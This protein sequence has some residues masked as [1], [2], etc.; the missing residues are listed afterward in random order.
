MKANLNTISKRAHKILDNPMHLNPGIESD[1]LVTLDSSDKILTVFHQGTS[2]E[3]ELI[4]GEVLS[5]LVKN[6][7]ISEVWKI[8]YREVESFLRDENHLQAFG[9]PVEELDKILTV[10][11]ITLIAE[12]IKGRGGEK[13]VTLKEIMFDW[14]N[15]SLVAKNQWA[16]EFLELVGFELVFCD[17]SLLTFTNFPKDLLR[18]ELE[19]LVQKIL[20]GGEIVLPMKVV[21][22]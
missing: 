1:F 16:S 8:N 15:L 13:F 7:T 20:G 18:S 4:F 2:G 19:I 9:E 11:K 6:K 5:I 10:S 12:A 17:E 22:V 3:I 14:E 21:A